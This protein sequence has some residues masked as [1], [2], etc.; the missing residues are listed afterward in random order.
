MAEHENT[1]D[2]LSD[3]E[4]VRQV[5]QS[6][7]KALIEAAAH[8]DEAVCRAAELIL[9]RNRSVIV[10]G[11][12]K[13]GLI[14]QKIAATLA[15]T[16]T[17]S[18][19]LH[20]AE[21]V[22]GD[23]GRLRADD[24]VLA[25]SNSGE[26]EEVNKILAPISDL[27]TPIVAIT[28]SRMSTL[29]RAAE[30]VIE[31]GNLQEAC[32]LRLAPTTSTTVMLAI[33]DA[34]AL[35]ISRSRNFRREDF[36]RR[37][38][39]GRLGWQLTPVDRHMRPLSQCRVASHQKTVRQVFTELSRPG[40]RSGAILLT[41]D[42]DELCGIFT[43]SDLA[44]LFE[45]DSGSHFDRQIREFMTRNPLC[46]PAGSLMSKAIEILTARQISELPVIDAAGRPIGLLDITDVIGLTSAG[47]EANE[48][49][50]VHLSINKAA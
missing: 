39:A 30:I 23:L 38:P 25:L 19:F 40:R 34:L 48:L 14:G 11:M 47:T 24:I 1:S 8:L 22:H 37:H 42:H 15:S 33:G 2:G 28:R 44:R 27:N 13:A 21:A 17:P 7:G 18:H 20:P 41:N 45:L 4:F 5:I 29:G 31:L 6:E 32:P 35:L 12:G 49:H 50:P 26:T 16:G 3:L 46:L 10:T 43:D 9:S 36:G